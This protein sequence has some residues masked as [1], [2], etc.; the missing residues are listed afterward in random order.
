MNNRNIYAILNGRI[1]SSGGSSGEVVDAY[2]KTQTDNLLSDK[3]NKSDVYT[4]ENV[5]NLL[6]EKADINTVS[7]LEK[8][9]LNKA[10]VSDV[11]DLQ[12]HIDDVY[13]KT[14]TDNL[15]NK[16]VDNNRFETL[17]TVMN[18]SVSNK[19]DSTTVEVLQIE[20]D[21]K[22]NMSDVTNLKNKISNVYT[23]SEV[24]NLL[25]NKVDTNTFIGLQTE[26]SAKANKSDVYT[27]TQ[28]D[29]LLSDK[30]NKSDVYTKENVDNLL[31]EKADI[32][33]VSDL[34][35]DLLN[36]ANVSD[37]RSLEMRV[38]DV[39]GKTVTVDKLLDTTSENPVQNKVVTQML[40]HLSNTKAEWTDFDE[41]EKSMSTT[42]GYQKKNL[43]KNTAQTQTING[44]TF[45]VNDDGTVIANGTATENA[46]LKI[47]YV[48]LKKNTSY[49]LSGLDNYSLS[50]V[51]ISLFNTANYT[52]MATLHLNPDFT[53]GSS[54]VNVEVRCVVYKGYTADGVVYKPMIRHA[55]ITDDTYK[56][57]VDDVDTR[58]NK[59]LARIE[60]LEQG[61]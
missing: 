5:D 46:V 12:T 9:L 45:T 50:T 60:A 14:Q 11:T 38:T 4:K 29:N 56:P 25:D 22:A 57:Y 61:V 16:K 17:M 33:T 32:N 37:V 31:D 3:V 39:E 54:D 58:L 13:T 28:T 21:T 27:K 55:E 7:D 41:L 34:E 18:E 47:S 19:A 53:I 6:D 44:I 48:T 24:D 15:L 40:N 43:L 59:L 10:N 36:K 30:V 35:K 26:V 8:D 42:L 1:K 23:K 52:S 20:V 51:T 2:T 49:I